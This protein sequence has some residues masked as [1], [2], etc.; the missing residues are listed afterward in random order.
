MGDANIDPPEIDFGNCYIKY[1]LNLSPAI[2]PAARDIIP[3][4]EDIIPK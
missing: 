2:T 1:K 3:T 4:M